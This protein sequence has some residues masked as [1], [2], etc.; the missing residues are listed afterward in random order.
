MLSPLGIKIDAVFP[1]GFQIR[2]GFRGSVHSGK[3]NADTEH[4]KQ[5][6]L[7]MPL[8]HLVPDVIQMESGKAFFSY[9][10]LMT[11]SL[12]GYALLYGLVRSA[13]PVTVQV[14]VHVKQFLH[15]GQD[16]TDH[17]IILRLPM[18]F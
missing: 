4:H 7:Q 16:L 6:M 15:M 8:Q 13:D 9:Q 11:I 18:Q 14:S 3:A 17:Q 10:K 5:L 2:I 1:H 12:D